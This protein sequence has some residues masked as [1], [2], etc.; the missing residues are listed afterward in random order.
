MPQNMHYY[1]NQE[2]WGYSMEILDQNETKNSQED[3]LQV[4]Y[5]YIWDP[6]A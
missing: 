5:V 4:L 1:S 3:K 2:E 6:R